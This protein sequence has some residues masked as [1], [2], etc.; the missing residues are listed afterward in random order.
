VTDI[1]IRERTKGAVSEE[2]SSTLKQGSG[3]TYTRQRTAATS[4]VK[5]YQTRI[6]SSARKVNLEFMEAEPYLRQGLVQAISGLF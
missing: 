1:Q 2:F 3:Q 4:S 5:K 6:A